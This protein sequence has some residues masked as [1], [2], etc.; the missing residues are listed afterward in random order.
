MINRQHHIPG[1]P[2]S[3]IPNLRLR[4]GGW[5]LGLLAVLASALSFGFNGPCNFTDDTNSGSS[6][7][8]VIKANSPNVIHGH[9]SGPDS[10]LNVPA[11]A[12]DRDTEI[13]F[14]PFRR[15]ED[16]PKSLPYGCEFLGGANLSPRHKDKV[17]FNKGREADSYV[18]L[19]VNVRAEELSNADIYLMEFIDGH[20][21]IVLP[22]KK[23]KVHKDG[24][25]AGYIGPDESV[26]A[27][28]TGIRPFCWAVINDPAVILSLYNLWLAIS[29]DSTAGNTV[30]TISFPP[31]NPISLVPPVLAPPKPAVT[32]PPAPAPGPIAWW[33]FDDTS[34]ATAYDSSGNNNHGRVYGATWNN[35]ALSFDGVDDYV[36]ITNTS[37]LNL[38]GSFSIDAW[39]FPTADTFGVI[40]AKWGDTGDWAAQRSYTLNANFVRRLNFGISD[41]ARQ[42]DGQF[43]TCLTPEGALTLNEWHHV[44]AVYDKPTGTWK[45]YINGIKVAERKD[46]PIN[47]TIS[48][49]DVAIGAQLPS[50]TTFLHAFA[51][52]IDEVK[53]Y[54]Y[55]LNPSEILADYNCNPRER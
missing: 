7:V 36:R 42:E 17:D 19:P 21:V 48:N 43:H 53:I 12:V 20:W 23:G 49:A 2:S 9:N 4:S 39:I 41:N 26:P 24:P 46:N 28:L 14:A 47:L 5:R 13:A 50:S 35:G 1:W 29:T 33:K 37:L 16:L 51:G 44:T 31:V 11:E 40:L 22:D 54:N 30:P 8:L 15:N 38:P 10:E 32:V 55:A 3:A 6:D 27:K 45:I 52:R 34:G 18:I 25:R